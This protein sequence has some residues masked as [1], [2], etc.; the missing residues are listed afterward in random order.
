L[1][2]IQRLVASLLHYFADFNVRVTV[3]VTFGCNASLEG[4]GGA[5]VIACQTI[6]A[7]MPPDRLILNHFY[8]LNRTDPGAGP[9]AI[10]I[11]I[12]LKTSC[13]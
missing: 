1:S 7:V 13:H 2:G 10:A 11:F 9:A 8:I 4:F 12:N 5:P 3:V 6:F